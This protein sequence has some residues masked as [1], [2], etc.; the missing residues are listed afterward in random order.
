MRCG[1]WQSLL[2]LLLLVSCSRGEEVVEVDEF[3]AA[4]ESATFDSVTRLGPHH[5]ESIITMDKQIQGRTHSSTE[6][7]D[8]AWGDWDNF[9]VQR[10]R[11]GRAASEVRVVE[12]VAYARSGS[13]R[14]READDAELYRLEIA[15]SW[16]TWDRALEA[17]RGC[18]QAELV[19][20]TVV[21]GRPARQYGL[22]LASPLAEECTKGHQPLSLE[23]S[24]TLDRAHA[25][26]LAAE[27]EASYAENGDPDRQVRL[28]LLLTRAD[29]G[30]F[31]VLEVPGGVRR[32]GR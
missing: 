4:S 32:K 25:V 13:G 16:N 7:L 29:I 22:S 11:D 15:G 30:D 19:G 9:R 28:H 14:F 6:T 27:L 5:L 31:P 20:D 8:I 12:A 17:F 1:H 3:L 18:V 2:P 24:M 23:G 10:I 21:E 26:R